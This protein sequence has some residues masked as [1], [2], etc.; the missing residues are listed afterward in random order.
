MALLP[1]RTTA[2]DAPIAA[3]ETIL[4]ADLLLRQV[5]RAAIV[6]QTLRVN[7]PRVCSRFGMV[8]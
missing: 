7:A 8:V 3:A 6:G 1:P 5:D 2:F 4:F